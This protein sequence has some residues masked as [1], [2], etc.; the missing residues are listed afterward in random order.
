MEDKFTSFDEMIETLDRGNEIEF[1]FNTK[2]YFLLPHWKDDKIKGYDI[3]EAFSEDYKV[4]VDKEI[5]GNYIIDG[6]IFRDIVG[7][8]IITFRCF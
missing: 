4:C 5:L 6:Y 3:G 2:N 7:D 8:L 1:I